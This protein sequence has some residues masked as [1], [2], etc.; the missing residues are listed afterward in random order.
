MN[1]AMIASLGIISFT[2]ALVAIFAL[3]SRGLLKTAL[4]LFSRKK[5]LT[6]LTIMALVV[7]SS[8]VTGS[9]AVGD[10]MRYAIV[11]GVYDDLGN[12]DEVVSSG[13]LF[14]E[15][16]LGDVS[17][18][19]ALLEVTDAIAPLIVLKGSA[20]NEATGLTESRTNILGYDDDLLLGFGPFWVSGDE[21]YYDTLAP[22]E[23][24]INRNLADKLSAQTGDTITITMRNPEFSI[25]SIYSHLA[26]QSWANVT[27][28][29]VVLDRGVGRL[30]L[31]TTSITAANLF[32]NLTYLQGLIGA[33]SE[34][35]TVLVSNQ[36]DEKEGLGLTNEAVQRLQA[37]LDDAIGYRDVAINVDAF[38]YIRVESENVFFDAEYLTRVEQ[39]ATALPDVEAVSP[40]TSYFVNNL[41]FGGNAVPYSVVTGLDPVVDRDFGLFVE[42]STAVE[43]DGEIEDDEII[44]TNYTAERLGAGVGDTVSVNYT[45]YTRAYTQVFR[46]ADFTVAHVV[47]ITGK[48]HDENL[49]PPIPGIR[50]ESSCAGWD[51][52]WIDG[53]QMRSEMTFEDLDYWTAYGGTPKAYITLDK[54]QQLWSNDLGTLTTIKVKAGNATALLPQFRSQ[55][56]TSIA[57]GDAGIVVA[58]VKQ[59]GIESAEGVQLLTET[60][61]SF[62]A[63]AIIAGIILVAGLVGVIMEDR[64]REIG[65][66]GA[67]GYSRG[68][69]TSVFGIEG[70]LLS[71][72][73]SGIGIFAGLLVAGVCILL[74]NTFWSNIMEG[75][76]VSLHF[77]LDTL[78]LGFA[79]GLLLS[80]LAFTLFAYWTTRVP[81]VSALKELDVSEGRGA[82][83]P[84]A[85]AVLGA[86]MTASYFLLP[87]DESFGS[88][89]VLAGPA[90]L[91]LFSPFFLRGS[92][93]R[94][95]LHVGM[96]LAVVITVVVDL[97]FVSTSGSVPFLLFFA[98]GFMLILALMVWLSANMKSIGSFVSGALSGSR[99]YPVTSKMALLSPSRKV[100]RTCLAISIFAVVI[101]TYLG[102]S[103]NISG[104]Q[105][106][107]E[108]IVEHQGAGY[109][110]IAESSM[111]L[112]FDLGSAEERARNNLSNF[113]ANVEVAQFLT[114]GEPGGSCSNL[115][116][117]LPPKLIGANATFVQQSKL[118]F[119]VPKESPA[120]IWPKLDEAQ[121]DGSIPAI[122]DLNT[123]VW[124]FGKNVGDRIEIVDEHG[125]EREL[126]IVGILENSIFPGAVFVS[127]DDLD[128]LHPTTAEF[129]LFLFRT[130]NALGL[131][132]Y[133]ESN[134]QAYGMDASLV[135]DVVKENLSVEWS[136]MGLFQAFL[137]FGLLI[138]IF[139]LASFSSRSVEERK[140]EIGMMK[141][142][143]MQ[144]TQISY[145]FLLENLFIA[146]LGSLVG[147]IAGLLVAFT[148]FGESS[149]VG[150]G[151]AIPWLALSAVLAVVVVTSLLATLM[152]ARRAAGLHPVEALKRDQ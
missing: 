152:P 49:M 95:A 36:G 41:S 131:V 117:N 7:G 61:L 20:R 9:L 6:V 68:Q 62:G 60:F 31:E 24:I 145:V 96:L 51:P 135:D 123:I 133:L 53:E 63:I 114:Y 3:R 82:S 29:A 84:R 42:N 128:D 126:V 104:Q 56:N 110:V 17:I 72:I 74:T 85:F 108:Q 141:S 121:A 2:V 90:F 150:Y 28:T 67:L 43:I 48:A 94:I 13:G 125:N 134:L 115:R 25:E 86:V 119:E 147:V 87:M 33:P 127:E 149:T 105:A 54:A 52:T 80:F 144:R 140:H 55:L 34:I 32:L 81:V 100:R 118:A 26:G 40:L 77:T 111:D 47:D 37:A 5:K 10:S 103:V 30:N 35:S 27:V 73:A 97:H 45:I 22:G 106:N 15:S 129:N 38:G 76:T 112:R 88:L 50:G 59:Q 98:S 91:A 139:G 18:D 11:E 136:Y 93:R 120:S 39:I 64:R 46:T 113:P 132:P 83:V 75:T 109:D 122:G 8:I 69:I 107:L 16:I 44:I 124:I 148:F 89:A 70:F 66:L 146:V 58:P 14:N 21:S 116:K 12:V 19:P 151:A 65:T 4:R 57:A 102:L 1:T 143:G 138:G 78:V 101:F 23:A 92:A 99:Q 71:A 142:L 137:L 79:A 130:D